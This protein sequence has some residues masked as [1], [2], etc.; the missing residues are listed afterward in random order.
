MNVRNRAKE[1]LPVPGPE[2]RKI[3]ID[4]LESQITN[5]ARI[6]SLISEA[7]NIE[8]AYEFAKSTPQLLN[9]FTN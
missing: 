9:G 5:F 8:D 7:I 6:F 2:A 1:L 3:T 4:L